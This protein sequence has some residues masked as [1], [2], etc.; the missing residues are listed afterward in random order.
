MMI[1]KETIEG[2]LIP[3]YS[4]GTSILYNDDCIKVMKELVNNNVKVDKVITSPPYNIIRPNATDRG[5][6][7]YKDGMSNDDYI[8]WVL[9]VFAYYDKLLNKNGCILWNMSYGCEN[10]TLMNLCVAEIIKNTNFTLAD[11]LVWKKKSATP[12]NVSSNKMTR[13]C[14]F[15]YV[16]CRD[17]EFKSFTTNKRIVGFRKNTHQAIYEN[18]FNFFEAKNNDGS[19]NL[20]KATFSSDFVNELIDR[21]V[22]KDDI[23][24]DN[25]SGTGT[26]M[27]SCERNNI[28]GI[29]V[30]L[31]T[32][33]CEFS[34]NRLE[35]VIQYSIFDFKDG[36]LENDK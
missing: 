19:N 6:D 9:S 27:I 29:Y 35:N 1:D 17:D 2:Q 20:N 13:I 33:Q 34:I 3:F 25:F 30:E 24:L 4:N 7:V 26:T 31:S 36:L 8:S 22:L 28:K 11:I 15:V 12:N 21:Y 18:R 10:T 16:F 14:E 32:E 5:Y 23:V